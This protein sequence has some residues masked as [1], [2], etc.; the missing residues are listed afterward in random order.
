MYSSKSDKSN[1]AFTACIKLL[2][3]I[4]D[5]WNALS[6]NLKPTSR[7]SSSSLICQEKYISW[8]YSPLELFSIEC[9]KTRI[10]LLTT[11]NQNLEN[12]T[13]SQWEIEVKTE[14]RLLLVL[15]L[16]GWESGASFLDQ[17]YKELKENQSCPGLFS[18]LNWK[19]FQHIENGFTDQPSKPSNP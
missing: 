19:L 2:M 8:N 15:K 6:R 18:T 14:S 13:R 17:S 7:R 11:V 12:I 10:K 9:R 1:L 16:I 5:S 4:C 3:V